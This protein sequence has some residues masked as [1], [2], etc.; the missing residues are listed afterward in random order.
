MVGKS[1]TAFASLLFTI[2]QKVNNLLKRLRRVG[3]CLRLKAAAVVCVA[4]GRGYAAVCLFVCFI[5][6]VH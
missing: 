5:P 4:A 1:P 2:N 6:T 3:F